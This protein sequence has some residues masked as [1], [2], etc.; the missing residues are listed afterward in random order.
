MPG[1]LDTT[2]AMLA[3]IAAVSVLHGLVLIAV[4]IAGFKL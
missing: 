2:N 4:G 3:I 1:T